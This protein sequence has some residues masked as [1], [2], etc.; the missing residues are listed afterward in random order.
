M[1]KKISVFIL[2]SIVLSFLFSGN[3]KAQEKDKKWQITASAKFLIG[4][5]SPIPPPTQVKAVYT[6][7]PKLNPSLGVTVTRKLEGRFKDWGI[8]GGVNCNFR[9]MEATT[10][11]EDLS[12]KM[13]DKDNPIRGQ[14]FGDNLSKI[15]NGYLAFPFGISYKIPQKTFSVQ[16]GLYL[17]VLLQG[18][19][20]TTIDG[21]MKSKN[22]TNPIEIDLLE[23]NFSDHLRPIDFGMNL[24][25]IV[26]PW[27]RVGFIAGLD[28]GFTPIVRKEF[29]AIPFK[30]HNVYA[31]IGISYRLSE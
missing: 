28:F 18:R 15:H 5:S 1:K 2:S 19:F 21:K 3:L 13:G 29:D 23:L 31:S 25:F 26:F 12:I 10:K 8:Y 6:W 22:T 24:N 20:E 9:G 7:F 17:A 27:E 11:I 30:L 16:A 14:F 4:A